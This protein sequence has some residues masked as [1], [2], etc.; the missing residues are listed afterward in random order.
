MHTFAQKG[1]ATQQRLPAKSTMPGRA[2][3]GQSREVSSIL[4]LQRTI[5]DQAIQQSLQAN[6]EELN[7]ASATTASTRI[8]HDFSRIP[9]RPKARARIHLKLAVGTPGDLYE[10][11]ADRVAEQ[12]IRMPVPKLRGACNYKGEGPECSVEFGSR[13]QPQRML[14]QGNDADES[15]MPPILQKVVPS[16]GQPLD[17]SARAWMEPRFGHDFSQVRIHTGPRAVEAAEAFNARA[18]TFGLNVVFGHGQ[19]SPQSD[20]GRTLLAH[21]LAHV[22]Q[23]RA[24]RRCSPRKS[25]ASLALEDTAPRVQRTPAVPAAA[26]TALA[27]AGRYL[28]SCILGAAFGIGLDLAIQ[29]GMAWWRN[30]QFRWNS[31]FAFVSGIIGCVSGV[32]GSAI[33]RAIF[34]STGG[35]LEE[36]LATKAAVWVITWLYGKFPVVPLA[37]LLKWLAKKGCMDASELPPGVQPD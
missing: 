33:S 1:K 7:A 2:H 32:A 10:Q 21:E 25:Q 16:S 18:F 20:N 22:V 31:C 37:I 3:F 27:V 35:H 24:T 13:V 28:L 17:S 19:Y 6:A 15:A 14:I 34:R 30:Q 5:G 9:L 23:Q 36:E 26:G 11:E 4:R 8:A 12:V 29:R